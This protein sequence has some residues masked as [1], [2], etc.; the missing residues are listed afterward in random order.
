MIEQADLVLITTNHTTF[1][2]ELIARKAKVVLD[3]RNALVSY[4][5]PKKYYKL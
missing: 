2:Y 5:K 1:P 3:T 4:G